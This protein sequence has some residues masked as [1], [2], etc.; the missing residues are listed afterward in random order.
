MNT[1]RFNLEKE[2]EVSELRKNS[3]G[4]KYLHIEI[5]DDDLW[6]DGHEEPEVEVVV[7]FDLMTVQRWE[8]VAEG[9]ATC[10]EISG[11]ARKESLL[12]RSDW[13]VAVDLA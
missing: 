11:I 12:D 2:T 10:H 3:I 5:G 1:R 4:L 9:E 6:K 13:R 7:A 8:S